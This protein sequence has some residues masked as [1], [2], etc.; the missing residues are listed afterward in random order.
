MTGLDIGSLVPVQELFSAGLSAASLKVYKTGQNCYV[1]FCELYA[2]SPFPA[3]EEKLSQFVAH[4]FMAGLSAGTV[5]S[6]LSAVCHAQIGLGLGDPDLPS[7][8]RLEYIIKGYRRKSV[9][10]GGRPRLPITPA[11]LRALKAVW[12]L[13][14]NS[15]SVSMLW[16]ASCLCFFGFLRSGEIVVP[17]DS[18][19]DPAF[20]LCYG[21]VLVD[22]CTNPSVLSVRLKA[23]KTDPFRKGVSLVIGRGK[24]DICLVAAVLGYMVLRGLAPGPL[25]LFSDGSF[26]T[27]PRFVSAIRS[28]LDRA[29]I[30]SKPYL[31]HSFRIGPATTA[32][33]CEIQDSRIKILGRWQSSAYQLYIRTPPGILTEVASQLL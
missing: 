26:L 5:K 27:R 28:A 24:G 14:G 22:S 33:S 18:S 4:L 21:D 3:S 16:A 10:S 13:D 15:F 12:F 8:P 17:S 31:G 30:D 20:H 7:M 11:I 9:K 2:H 32:A 25:F 19:F 1:R 6:Y 29:G 23:S